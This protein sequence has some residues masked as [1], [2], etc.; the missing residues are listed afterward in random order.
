MHFT[1][2]I[3]RQIPHMQNRPRLRRAMG[4]ARG[5]I[6][7]GHG[8]RR[9]RRLQGVDTYLTM[10]EALPQP[11]FKSMIVTGPLL[12]EDLYDQLAAGPAS[13]RC[14]SSNSTERWKRPSC[15]RLRGFHG[16]LQHHVRN[17]LRRRPSLIIPRSTPVKSSSSEP[18]IFAARG[19]LEYIP[20]ETV[21]R[22]GRH[23]RTHPSA[24]CSNTL[25]YQEQLGKFPHDRL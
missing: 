16:R 5:K 3:P 22:P 23:A 9:R 21:D 17:H 24:A 8:R 7:A 2:Y 6:R 10:L 14:E 19:L 11:E 12:A 13:S 25:D 1:G 20:W 4:I 18:G 15:R